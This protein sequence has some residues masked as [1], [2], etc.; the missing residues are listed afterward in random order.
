MLNENWKCK[1]LRM[2]KALLEKNIARGL[3]LPDIKIYYE[4]IVTKTVWLW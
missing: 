2:S 4:M 3:T 1:E